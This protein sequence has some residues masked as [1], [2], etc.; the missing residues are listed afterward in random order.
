V[1]AVGDGV[2]DL[3]CGD[4]VVAI[5]P[6]S[7]ATYAVTDARLTARMPRRLSFEEA[8]AVPIAFLTAA[9]ALEVL[10]AIGP[11]R[12]VLVHAATGGVGMAALQ[13]C[14]RAGADVLA[15]AGSPRKRRHL[16]T[17]GVRHVMDSRSLAFAGEVLEATGGEG[18][19][20]VLN[21]LAGEFV[22]KSLSVLR[23]GGC[24]VEI[25]K[26]DILDPERVAALEPPVRYH[27]FD[28]AQMCDADPAAVGARLRT[29]CASLDA[30]EL[31]PLPIRAFDLAQAPLAFR[32]M[33]QARHIGKV[34]LA[35]PEAIV[36]GER[37]L[38]PQ[39][40]Y[41]VTGGLGALGRI[42]ARRLIDSGARSVVLAGRSAEAADDGAPLGPDLPEGVEVL[43]RRCDVSREEDVAALVAGLERPLRGIVH[44][45]GVL[46]D[47]MVAGQTPERLAAV[48]A[49]KAA[50]ARILHELTREHEL[51]FFVLFS[52]ASA[53]LGSPGQAN[54]AAANACL[55]ALAHQRRAAGLAATSIAWGPWDGLG[56]AAGAGDSAS[57]VR[58]RGI[59][60][61][62]PEQGANLLARALGEAPAHVVVLPVDWA[63]LGR[64]LPSGA[65]PPLLED[66]VAAQGAEAAAGRDRLVAELRALAPGRRRDA[67]VERLTRQAATVLGLDPRAAVDPAR[68][69]AELGLDSLTGVELAN[70]V[71]R[72]TG[73]ALPATALFD[74]PTLDALAQHL[75]DQ[76]VPA[77]GAN[78]AAGAERER[79]LDHVEAL[80]DA[81]VQARVE[82]SVTA[83][84]A[85]DGGTA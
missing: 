82:R 53:V 25:G 24:F 11:G 57:R 64:A 59:D 46:D 18:V 61:I 4:A 15:T 50:G 23:P 12:R 20:V 19:D 52:S 83:L 66:F 40:T 31:E 17:L 14:R 41:L 67:L 42:A 35:A 70:V 71:G 72:M 30:G 37:G 74:H 58:A 48:M 16:E 56:M 7:F 1:A 39:A 29:L 44:A 26:A 54:Y 75:L 51:D 84:L 36:R 27:A 10:A 81:E 21:S 73:V 38:D 76:L 6:A 2:D 63:A 80:S 78:G 79:A 62:S 34:V 69:L 45:A 77:N 49:P 13:L 8:A 55:D 33:A 85:R 68:P 28:L 5:A 9:H 47:A 43:V 65:V 32:H 60:A 3:A 22:A